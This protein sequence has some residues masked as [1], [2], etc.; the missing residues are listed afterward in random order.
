MICIGK[1]KCTSEKGLLLSHVLVQRKNFPL[2]LVDIAYKHMSVSER[3][4][5]EPLKR[6]LIEANK[7]IMLKK[8]K[9]RKPVILYCQILTMS[10]SSLFFV[11]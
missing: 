4:F 2:L 6:S 7:K 8:H 3:L 10:L 11:I 9:K 5:A 1:T